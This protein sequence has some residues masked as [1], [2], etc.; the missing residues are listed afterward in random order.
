MEKLRTERTTSDGS[1]RRQESRGI[2]LEIEKRMVVLVSRNL[3]FPYV[4]F[5]FH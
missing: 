2:V 1:T 5:Y 3:K 4:L